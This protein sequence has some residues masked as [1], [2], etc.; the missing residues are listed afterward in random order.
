MNDSEEKQ[1]KLYILPDYIRL[2]ICNNKKTYVN[3]YF[4]HPR[5]ICKESLN[6][7]DE[8]KFTASLSFATEVYYVRQDGFLSIKLQV[9]GMGIGFTYQLNY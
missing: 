7:F 5:V 1:K 6:E 4:Y 2:N 8:R 3:I 9:L